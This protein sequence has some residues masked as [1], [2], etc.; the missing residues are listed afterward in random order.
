MDLAL[1]W[2]ELQ[3]NK[4]MQRVVSAMYTTPIPPC[5]IVWLITG[6]EAYVGEPAKST[7]SESSFAW[8]F[9]AD[10]GVVLH[11]N[12]PQESHFSFHLVIALEQ[13]DAIIGATTEVT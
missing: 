6:A 8:D 4:T 7:N 13:P 11:E 10:G 3:S 12:F 1:I 5:E 9:E 2:Q